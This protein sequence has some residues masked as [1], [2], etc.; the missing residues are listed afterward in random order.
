MALHV[1]DL[2]AMD[3][4][5]NTECEVRVGRGRK[6]RLRP[7]R[8]DD[9]EALVDMAL[10]STS[11]DLRL[12]FFGAVN[13]TIGPLTSLLTQFD[14]DRHIAVAAYDPAAADDGKGIL[15]VVRLVLA[16]DKPEGEFA[17]MVRSDQAG[18]GL[19]H[20]L[21]RQMLGWARERGLTRVRAEVLTENKRMLR[22]A[23]EFGAVVQPQSRDFHTVQVAIDLMAGPIR[24]D[25]PARSRRGRTRAFKSPLASREPST[26]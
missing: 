1:F 4:H 17:I 13:P 23:R 5:S 3:D 22:L 18:H 9:A 6:L 26:R 25:T 24:R 12:R 11:E 19:G 2:T 7:I 21:M 20:C 16:P 8:T 15:G 14:R 10:R